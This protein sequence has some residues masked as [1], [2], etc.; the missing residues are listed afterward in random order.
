MMTD[1]EDLKTHTI[2]GVS[3]GEYMNY[4]FTKSMSELDRCYTMLQELRSVI[5]GGALKY[6]NHE[7]S[8]HEGR[9]I[10]PTIGDFRGNCASNQSSFNN[11]RIKEWEE[12]KKEDQ[13]PTTKI[14][15][16]KILINNS[17]C[18]LVID[19][20]SINNLVSKELVDFLKLP[21]EICPIEG[22]QVCRVPLTIGKFYKEEILCIVD[23]ID[24][25]HIL[26][27]KPW[28]CEV[29]G[30]Y[31]VKRNLYIFSWKG[32]RI[33]MVPHKV[34]PQLPKPEVKVEEKIAMV[35][36]KVTPQLPK[37]EVLYTSDEDF[38]NTWMEL[39]TKQHRGE[40][41]V[42]GGGLL[43]GMLELSKE[44]CRVSRRKGLLSN[45]KSQI[46]ITEDCDDGSRTEEQHLVVPYSDEEIICTNVWLKQEMVCAQR[47]T[48][49]PRIT[50]LKI[51]EEHLEDKKMAIVLGGASVGSGILMMTAWCVEDLIRNGNKRV[52]MDAT[53]TNI[54]QLVPVL[55]NEGIKGPVL[56]EHTKRVVSFAK[57]VTSEPS[58]K[59][60]NFHTL[61]AW[62]GKGANVVISLESA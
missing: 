26:L 61:L 24:D 18:S 53:R 45:P 5:V 54:E 36:P 6:K 30:K 55:G 15:H 37:P 40:F 57:L 51:L 56:T 43:K 46:F 41:V 31:D 4:G 13:V 38:G 60:V 27:G 23:D 35:S 16:S 3:S 48:W 62:S 49:D 29:N 44:I 50:W 33:A 14:F 17:V 1:L 21:M 20:C 9:R 11:G 28:R 10:R 34:T 12:E 52:N 58:R 47:R 7:G 39:K 8:K 19:G 25:C 22:Y 32:K 42:P 2:C 59:H